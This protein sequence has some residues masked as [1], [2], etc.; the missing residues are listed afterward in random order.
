MSQDLELMMQGSV[1]RHHV[2][3]PC[4]RRSCDIVTVAAA[5]KWV[6]QFEG[7]EFKLFNWKKIF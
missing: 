2:F 6:S 3:E 5:L 7:E 1:A 4:F